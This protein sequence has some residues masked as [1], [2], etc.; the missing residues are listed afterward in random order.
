MTVV[1]ICGITTLEQALQALESGADQLGF[2][3]APSRRQLAPEI[4]AGIIQGARRRFPPAQHPWLAVGVF[5]NQPLSFIVA[6]AAICELDIVQLSGEEP[7]EYCRGVPC[8]IYK[9][10]HLPRAAIRKEIDRGEVGIVPQA[11]ELNRPLGRGGLD[12][13]LRALRDSTRATRVLLDTGGAGRWG[14]TGEPFQWDLVGTI[15]GECLVAGGLTPENVAKAVAIT[16][17]WGVDV[18]SGVE[19]DGRKDP[20]LIR[21]FIT[22]VRMRDEVA[23]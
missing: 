1:K 3:M 7:A 2:V 8:P 12:E 21:A 23:E 10:F 4:A 18:S 19:R 6:A 16:R 5:A 15:A 14:G 20:D 9:A 17:P 13:K 11:D 22:E